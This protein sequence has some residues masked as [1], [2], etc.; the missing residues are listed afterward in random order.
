MDKTTI[1]QKEN[2]GLLQSLK[3]TA[4]L[5]NHKN[6]INYGENHLASR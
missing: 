2:S 1:P 6:V 4:V 5:L 3:Q